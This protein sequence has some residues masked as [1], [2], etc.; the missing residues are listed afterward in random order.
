[1]GHVK[2]AWRNRRGVDLE[3]MVLACDVD[4]PGV[5]VLDGVVGAMVAV[6]EARRGRPRRAAQDL[7]TEAD[8]E[9]WDAAQSLACQLDRRVEHGRVAWTV[10]QD[11]AVRADRLH[12]R[13]RG[14]VR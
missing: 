10:G 14:G 12:V 11:Q 13:P 1:M 2:V 5:E 7:V 6:W 3:L 8:A 4:T 9:Q